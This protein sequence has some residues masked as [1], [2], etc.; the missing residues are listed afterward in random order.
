[1]DAKEKEILWLT[2]IAHALTHFFEVLLPA[3]TIFV[4]QDLRTEMPTLRI[5]TVIQVGTMMYLLYGLLALA[6]GPVADRFG[7]KYALAAG[8]FFSG[9]GYIVAGLAH[10]IA[11]MWVA[12]AV[13][14]VG[15][16]AYHPAGLALISKTISQRGRALGINGICG[17]IGFMTA[18][19]FGGICGYVYGWRITF[20]IAG[21]IGIV[22]GLSM[23]LLRGRENRDTEKTVVA[24][25]AGDKS[26]FYF[27]IFCIAMAVNG[28]VYRGNIIAMPLVFEE[29][30]A[31]VMGWLDNRTWLGIDGIGGRDGEIMTLGAT[32]L[33]TFVY[34]FGMVG[35]KLGGMAADRYDLRWAY[36]GFF[37]VASLPLLGIGMLSGW[38]LVA[39]AA[40]FITFSL[41]TQPIENSLVAR[42]TPPRWRSTFYAVKFIFVFGVGTL[43]V[44]I[45]SGAKN[46]WG[47]GSVYYI[48]SLAMV[49]LLLLIGGLIYIS[50]ETNLHQRQAK[51]AVMS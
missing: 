2:C 10:S 47:T 27:A 15:I 6:W 28:I 39:A 13:V 25:V 14:G 1:M 20:V 9:A 23:F 46:V 3:V 21:I 4:Y 35:Q 5:T 26:M 33:L 34:T 42:L 44:Y 37:S 43:A 16:A 48:L 7:A 32:L 36:F 11:A 31:S 29:N 50:R 19:L 41:G 49:L 30:M 38:P 51:P 22:A 17:T 8:M 18:P 24:P 12:F 45:V 40:I